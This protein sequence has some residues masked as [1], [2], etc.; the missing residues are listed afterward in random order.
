MRKWTR[1]EWPVFEIHRLSSVF[2]LVDIIY[3][4]NQR[5]DLSLLGAPVVDVL[6]AG[7]ASVTNEANYGVLCGRRVD[8][9][10][11]I[12]VGVAVVD[13]GRLD[14]SGWCCRSCSQYVGSE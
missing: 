12:F 2:E 4:S 1:S 9:M 7:A 11:F 8:V 13:W 14:R 5:L 6:N 3:V 10:G